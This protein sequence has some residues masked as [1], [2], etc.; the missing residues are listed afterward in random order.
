MSNFKQPLGG[1]ELMYHELQSRLDP[2]YFEKFSIFNYANSADMSKHT[3]YWNQ[4]SYDQAAVQFLRDIGYLDA[5]KSFVFVSHWQAESFRK[6][7]NI[8]SNKI[9]V[10][11]NACIGVKPVLEPEPGDQ[12]SKEKIKICYTS[13]P[14]RGLNVLLG[15]WKLLNRDDCELH[16][17]SSTK[18]YGEQF[19]AEHE[20]HYDPLYKLCKA[21][22]N[23]IYRGSIPND[24]LRNE[25]SDFR[26][27]AYPCTFEETS[28]ISVIDA[29]CA[30]LR[31]VT[32]S[33]GALPE[34]TE[35]WANVYSYVDDIDLHMQRFAEIL[36]KEIDIIASGIYNRRLFVQSKLYGSK[37][38]WDSRITEWTEYLKSL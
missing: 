32:S 31:V 10:I 16:V 3:I 22:P 18:I 26:I 23:V 6:M 33:I 11:Q 37:W 9:H 25:L 28:C 36:N 5:I 17:F 27:L 13:T 12:R 8:P 1:T 24:E 4:L 14:W 30:G 35:G 7:F 34:T 38:S 20:S 2:K 19:A 21:L 29:L 15:A